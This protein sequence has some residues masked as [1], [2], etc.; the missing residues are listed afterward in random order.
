MFEN[1]SYCV[2]FGLFER[3]SRSSTITIHGDRTIVFEDIGVFA[4]CFIDFA[5]AN[6]RLNGW[7]RGV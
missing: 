3:Q 5:F 7:M 2:I 6:K 4:E 1:R